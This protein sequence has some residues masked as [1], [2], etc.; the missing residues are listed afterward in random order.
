MNPE[1][2]LVTPAKDLFYKN[3]ISGNT[4]PFKLLTGKK[5]IVPAGILG[6]KLIE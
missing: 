2:P 3:R 1:N 6:W 5:R 4:R